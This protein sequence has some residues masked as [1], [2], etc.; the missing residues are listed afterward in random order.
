MCKSFTPQALF[1]IGQGTKAL[2]LE[3]PHTIAALYII[4]IFLPIPGLPPSEVPDCWFYYLKY[5]SKNGIIRPRG[6]G[7]SK[8]PGQGLTL[9]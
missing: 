1:L 3:H 6:Y 4:C 7:Q 8:W 5:H 2:P 9:H